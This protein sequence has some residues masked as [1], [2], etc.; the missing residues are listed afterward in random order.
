MSN[1]EE[2]VRE[3]TKLGI[4]SDR[5]S[6]FH[7]KNLE[8]FPFIMLDGIEQAE[9]KYDLERGAKNY[10]EYILKVKLGVQTASVER[11]LESLDKA[12]KNLF[13][14]EVSVIVKMNGDKVWDS[15][16]KEE[17]KNV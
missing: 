5:V 14:K 8:A 9:I 17:A 11:R 12:V 13:W 7:Q 16:P 15:M 4:V 3:L 2:K 6:E 10:V 1:S